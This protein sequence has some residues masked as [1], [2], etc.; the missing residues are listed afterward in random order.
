MQRQDILQ[1][2]HKYNTGTC[3]E[4]EKAL[5]EDWYLQFELKGIDNLADSD[6]EADLDK[7]WK[8]LP[9][10][11][12]KVRRLK[13][14]YQVAAAAAILIFVTLG[15]YFNYYPQIQQQKVIQ[16]IA[17]MTVPGGNKAILVLNNGKQLVLT[18]ANNG[19]LATQGS[20]A[21]NKT[22][23]GKII[24]QSNKTAS[25]T[26]DVDYNTMVTPAGGTYCL[27]LSDGTK[28]T[29]DATSSIHYP[30]TFVGNE[31]RVEITGQAYFEVA[32]NKVLPFRVTANGQTVEVLGTHFNINAYADEGATRTTL[33]EG[34]V[35]VSKGMHTAMLMPGQQSVIVSNTD[36]IAVKNADT[37]T[38]TA[39]KDGLFRFKRADLQTVMRQFARWYDVDIVYD[40]KISEAAITGKV[41]RSAN[42][43]RVLEILVKL[44]I[45]FRLDGKKI[46]IMQN[47]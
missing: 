37:E 12:Q 27:T 47:N 20:V 45:K 44:G 34:S 18:G 39:W 38:A 3:T 40:G 8:N 14:S 32:H 42:A 30:V 43:S 11:R 24:Y 31:R 41:Q 23:E 16:K 9:V 19:Q 5:V 29:L 17:H 33:L 2:L 28:V 13:I 36:D 46:I 6:R 22:A 26:G 4:S 35:K 7:I 15:F 1:L 25:L 10:H 21:V